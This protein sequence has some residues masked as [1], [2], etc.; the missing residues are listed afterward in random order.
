MKKEEVVT[1]IEFGFKERVLQFYFLQRRKVHTYIAAL[2]GLSVLFIAYL[3]SGPSAED[4]TNAKKTFEQWKKSPLD[5]NLKAEMSKSLKRI[6]GLERAKE[7]EIVQTLL[8]AGQ[9]DSAAGM[10]C[11]ERLRKE[12]PHH[13]AYA[14]ASLRIEQKEYQKA[15]EL[16]VALKE[17]MERDSV[18]K[19]K[20]LQGGSTLLT[21]NLLRIALLQKQVGNAPGEL[22]AWEE[23]RGILNMQ[24]DSVA[25]QLLE[26]NF[27]QNLGKNSFSLSEYISQR[28]R[29]IH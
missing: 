14:E 4:A 27:G 8:T 1:T 23:V 19:T 13:A 7:A 15:L 2:L 18:G 29:A 25:V 16:A 12:S 10:Q 6:S 17:Q 11:V 21:S 3:T 9:V 24:A 20:N 22:S 5:L 26:A 28:E